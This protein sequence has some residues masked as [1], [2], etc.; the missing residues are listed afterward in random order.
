[1]LGEL[2]AIA[3][4]HFGQPRAA[5]SN[6]SLGLL[7]DPRHPGPDLKIT[8]IVKGGPADQRGLNLRVG[9]RIIAID[10]CPAR[11]PTRPKFHGLLNDKVG[12]VLS[13][14][15]SPP[16]KASASGGSSRRAKAAPR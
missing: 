5:G 1:M 14:S 13:F 10:G 6:R 3:P 7:F 2:N 16:A 12:E 9:D 4:G 8:E 15:P 11:P